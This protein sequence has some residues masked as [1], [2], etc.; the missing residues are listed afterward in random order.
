MGQKLTDLCACVARVH[1]W[2]YVE[3]PLD[4]F[5][6]SEHVSPNST[7]RIDIKGWFKWLSSGMGSEIEIHS[8]GD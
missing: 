6:Q 1:V 2:R 4:S 8:S 3:N 7:S 5:L